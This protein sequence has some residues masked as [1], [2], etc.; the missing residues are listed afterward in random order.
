MVSYGQVQYGSPNEWVEVLSVT[1]NV[2]LPKS[3]N[4]VVSDK[5]DSLPFILLRC[6]LLAEKN[7]DECSFDHPAQPIPAF[8]IFPLVV[9]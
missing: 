2:Y 3:G 4:T 8:A 5:V 1:K 7:E 6:R 9:H